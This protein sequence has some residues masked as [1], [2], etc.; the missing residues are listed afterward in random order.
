MKLQKF[1]TEAIQ[2]RFSA[3]ATVEAL[4]KKIRTIAIET[5]FKKYK[6]EILFSG[7]LKF[8]LGGVNAKLYNFADDLTLPKIRLELTYFCISKLPKA[9]RDKLEKVKSD[10]K[11]GKFLGWNHYK[12]KIWQELDYDI[13][14]KDALSG[15][16][17]LNI[18]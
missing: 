18:E 17:N 10:Y 8:E 1:L 15:N 14:I 2:K 4:E 7:G 11:E 3:N 5:T 16:I 12:V 9:K 6:N 13:S